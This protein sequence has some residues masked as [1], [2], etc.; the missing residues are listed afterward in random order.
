MHAGSAGL[1]A[2]RPWRAPERRTLRRVAPWALLLALLTTWALWYPPSPDLAAQVF[3]STSSTRGLLAV[4]RQLVRQATTC[5]ATACCTRRSRRRWP[6]ARLGALSVSISV[7]ASAPERGPAPGTSNAGDR[8][9]VAGACGDLFIGRLTFAIGVSFGMPSLARGRARNRARSRRCCRSPG[10][11][12]PVAAAVP[13]LV[14]AA[15][16]VTLPQYRRARSRSARQARLIRRVALLTPE[17]G[18]ESFGFLSLLAA[19]GP[20]SGALLILLPAASGLRATAALYLAALALSTCWPRRWA[21]TP[22]GFGVLLV[23]GAPGRRRRRIEAS[24]RALRRFSAPGGR[25]ARPAIGLRTIA[26]TRERPAWC[27]RC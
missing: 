24:D 19:S 25:V 16:L 21:A 5:P 1:A 26:G 18:E 14:A 23:P 11:G 15:D 6:G 27:W 12:E 2:T 4:G 20:L 3:A 10:R 17:G 8:A 22:C 7:W 9:F 13:A